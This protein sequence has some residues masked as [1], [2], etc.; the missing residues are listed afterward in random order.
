M[1]RRGGSSAAGH[2][3]MS[4]RLAAAVLCV[5]VMAAAIQDEEGS[6]L[7]DGILGDD[8]IPKGDL[9]EG[10]IEDSSSSALDKKTWY[11]IPYFVLTHMSENAGTTSE[12]ACKE[13]CEQKP[14]CRSF[15]W[16]EDT[17]QC[18]YS[19]ES[20]HFDPEFDFFAKTNPDTGAPFTY[21]EFLGVKYQEPGQSEQF[22]DM[23]SHECRAKCDAQPKKCMSFSYRA[24]DK[25]C[26]T[27]G[28][29]LHYD[30]KWTYYERDVATI[31]KDWKRGSTKEVT[32]K[33]QFKGEPVEMSK[34]DK[35]EQGKEAVQKADEEKAAAEA[36]SDMETASSSADKEVAKLEVAKTE[37]ELAAA[38]KVQSAAKVKAD[39]A[40]SAAGSSVS[41]TEEE[42]EEADAKAKEESK[43]AKETA[44]EA[45]T[46][47]E[48][49]ESTAKATD[50][51]EKAKEDASEAQAAASKAENDA[52]VSDADS[53]AKKAK[54]AAAN[55]VEAASDAAK[56]ANDATPATKKQ[57]TAVAAAAEKAAEAAAGAAAAAEVKSRYQNTQKAF[58]D[59]TANERI[60]KREKAALDKMVKT[61]KLGRKANPFDESLEAAETRAV[62]RAAV[63]EKT[64]KQAK[65]KMDLSRA[66]AEEA[67]QEHLLTQADV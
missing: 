51:L 13:A 29:G 17:R 39:T 38:E 2:R 43:E 9:G 60:A 40:K 50:S 61:V 25:V 4:V 3:M 41:D 57:V 64:S 6:A 26:F 8:V 34:G 35:K 52:K 7:T 15:S 1:G 11:R 19:L 55:A 16:N 62:A 65:A 48:D 45:K 20:I 44:E 22:E 42:T 31:P 27:S 46:A 63:A 67:K 47:A 21:Y 37:K 36:K 58:T 54:D 53:D 56:N 59:N 33:K 32:A 66:Q 30:A 24:R 49:A 14:E 18:L 10:K 28:E 23:T 12:E 5:V